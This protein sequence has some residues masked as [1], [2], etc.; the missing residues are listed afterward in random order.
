MISLLSG[1]VERCGYDGVTVL[2]NGVGY[3]VFVSIRDVAKLEK[4]LSATVHISEVIREQSYDLYGFLEESDKELFET[5]LKVSGVGPRIALALISI[6]ESH[7]LIGAIQSSDINKIS[8]APGVG[9]RL[10]E[11]IVVEMKDKFKGRAYEVSSS[12]SASNSYHAQAEDAL[13]S[14]GFKKIDA[15]MMLKNVD[16]SLTVEEQVRMALKK[17]K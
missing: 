3:G 4:G 12:V 11:R 13:V 15:E 8:S 7:E 5:L 14:L 9:K 1:V 16:K 6:T 17:G 10:A 2:V